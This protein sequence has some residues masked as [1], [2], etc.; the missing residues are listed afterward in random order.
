MRKGIRR[1]LRK[2]IIFLF[3]RCSRRRK[4]KQKQFGRVNLRKVK[5]RVETQNENITAA[6]EA[7]AGHAA[8]ISLYERRCHKIV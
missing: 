8:I 6:G 5:K 4:K 3:D 2:N 1:E 7:R